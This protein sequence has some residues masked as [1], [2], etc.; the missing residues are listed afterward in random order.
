MR[1]TAPHK[2]RTIAEIARE[3]NQIW[4]PLHIDANPYVNAMFSVRSPNDVYGKDTGIEIVKWFLHNSTM[5][6]GLDADRIKAELMALITP[7]NIEVGDD[8]YWNDPDE[9]TCSGIYRVVDKLTEE[10]ENSVWLI[11]NGYGSSTEVFQH[12][13]S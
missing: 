2:Q 5:W 4:V 12:E 1:Q 9:D 8:V 6:T 7:L 11:T 13:L 10:G 3:I